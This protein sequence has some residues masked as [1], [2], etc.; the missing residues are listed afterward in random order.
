MYYTV[1]K[2]TN[3]INNKIYIG[4]HKTKDLKDDYM[5]SGK[6]LK[7]SIKKYGI[8]SFKKEYLEI[9]DNPEDMFEME[10]ELANAD[11]IKESSNYNLKVG[12]EGGFD[13]INENFENRKFSD[14]DRKLGQERLKTLWNDN[15]H[16]DWR[17]N[18]T[19]QISSGLNS[20]YNNGG[21]NGFKGKTHSDSMKEKISKLQKQIDRSGCKNPKAVGVID[22]DGNKFSTL[23]ECAVFYSVHVNTISNWIKCGKIKRNI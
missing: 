12:G 15:K 10:S 16:S 11:F 8:G 6:I 19:K 14:Y 17:N 22:N 7:Q 13:Y 4:C 9:F 18:T 21:I 1:Y 3:M 23:K 2:I 5:G 20:Y